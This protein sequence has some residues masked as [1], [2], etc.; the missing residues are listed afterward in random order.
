ML[1]QQTW[2]KINC[3]L[4]LMITNAD[5]VI[6]LSDQYKNYSYW[7]F[8]P[9]SLCGYFVETHSFCIVSGVLLKTMRKLS[10]STIFPHQKIW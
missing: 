10:L 1:R 9:I 7:Q 6:K 5:K 2:M 3:E 8:H 4:D